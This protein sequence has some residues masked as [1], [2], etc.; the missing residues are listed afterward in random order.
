M[1][2]V[3]VLGEQELQ[4][5]AAKYIFCATWNSSKCCKI[6]WLIPHFDKRSNWKCAILSLNAALKTATTCSILCY[7]I[8]THSHTNRTWWLIKSSI[9]P[10][11]TS[12]VFF[13]SL[14][15]F[16]YLP[17]KGAKCCEPS[18][19]RISVER[20]TSRYL[21]MKVTINFGLNKPNSELMKWTSY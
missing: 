10:S 16:V 19:W 14:A 18:I 1:Y 5:K 3:C 2:I 6:C 21:T 11:S 13:Q 9:L 4:N 8:H 12:A 15:H 7:C 20:I 17:I